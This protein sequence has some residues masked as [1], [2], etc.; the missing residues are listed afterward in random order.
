MVPFDLPTAVC[1]VTRWL[2]FFQGRTIVTGCADSTI[3]VFDAK[4]SVMQLTFQGHSDSVDFIE[5]DGE[6]IVSASADK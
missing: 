1:L 2:V 5:F 4:T 6:N 3:R